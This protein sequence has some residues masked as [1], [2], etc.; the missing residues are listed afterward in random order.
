MIGGAEL[1]PGDASISLLLVKVSQVAFLLTFVVVCQDLG[2]GGGI[3][4]ILAMPVFWH[5][6]LQP[7]FSYRLCQ[8]LKCDFWPPWVVYIDHTTFHQ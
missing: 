3:K 4:L 5:H 7:P 8:G 1:N 6:F 2:V